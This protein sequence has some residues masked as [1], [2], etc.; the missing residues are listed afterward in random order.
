MRC[1]TPNC[2]GNIRVT[3]NTK[4]YGVEWTLW[5]CEKC[6]ID[7]FVR[8]IQITDS[9]YSEPIANPEPKDYDSE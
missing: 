6:K 3:G 2:D 7:F 4:A 9:E 8:A 1:P 5:S